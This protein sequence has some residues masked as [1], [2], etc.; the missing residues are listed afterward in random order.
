MI[1]K[2]TQKTLLIFLLVSGLIFV[3]NKEVRQFTTAF[4]LKKEK[5]IIGAC[6]TYHWIEEKIDLNKYEFI[7]T[8]S[9]D[10]SLI[11]LGSKQADIVLSGRT[12]K[13][14]EPSFDFLVI[15]EGYSFLSDKGFLVYYHELDKYNIYTDLDVEL[16]K[17]DLSIEKIEKVDDV[18]DYLEK[19]IVITSW[20][21]TDYSRVEIVHVL[22]SSGE[23][24]ELSRRPVI[25]CSES[26]SDDVQE[27]KS[28]LNSI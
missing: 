22:K 4:L 6:P 19:G 7:P 8:T 14:N 3:F 23:R 9:T 16:V 27:I 28:F 12:L 15:G 17:N 24:L 1:K 18:Y 20:E 10:Q 2:I 5:I 21:N 25:Y 13:P 26:C 11:L